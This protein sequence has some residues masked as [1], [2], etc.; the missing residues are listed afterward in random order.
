MLPFFR[1][2]LLR[3]IWR[4]IKLCLFLL[5]AQAAWCTWLVYRYSTRTAGQQ[6]DAAVVLGAAAWGKNP[7]P[8]FRERINHGITL[9]RNGLVRK[10]I[11]TGGTPK[12]GYMTEAEVG[13]RYARARGV[14]GK[15]IL[16]ETTSRDTQQN[17]EN[18][19]ILLYNNGLENI[20]IISD[21]YHLARAAAVADYVGLDYQ[22]EPTPSSRYS[23]R[24]GA[25]FMAT[26]VLSLM[27]FQWWRVGETALAY[28][29]DNL[30]F[31]REGAV[32]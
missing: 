28:G 18:T 10:L 13:R 30:S 9:Y 23:G 2:S 1:A 16:L 12:P 15:D 21:P 24:N 19:K 32:R 11:F 17:L 3:Q 14:P 20:I 8:V 31:M 26:E 7:S 6:A 27:A 25:K 5:L 29:R 22:T 4:G